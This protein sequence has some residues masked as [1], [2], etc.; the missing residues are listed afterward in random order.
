MREGPA[1]LKQKSQNRSIQ[2]LR[3]VRRKTAITNATMQQSTVRR[4]RLMERRSRSMSTPAQRLS[5]AGCCV[6]AVV[7]GVMVDVLSVVVSWFFSVVGERWAVD[8]GHE[9]LELQRREWHESSRIF[10]G[11]W[12]IRETRVTS[13]QIICERNSAPLLQKINF[14]NKHSNTIVNSSYPK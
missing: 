13:A 11:R 7:D 2:L 5:Q 14:R 8:R 10:Y 12:K 9:K 1:I 6:R 3:C 4:Q